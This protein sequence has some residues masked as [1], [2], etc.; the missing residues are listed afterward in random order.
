MGVSVE[1]TGTTGRRPSRARRAAAARGPATFDDIAAGRALLQLPFVLVIRSHLRAQGALAL[2][3][4][5]AKVIAGVAPPA[6]ATA[7]GRSA[8]ESVLGPIVLCA[9]H[10]AEPADTGAGDG[11]PP[12]P[13]DGHCS[14]CTLLGAFAAIVAPVAAMLVFP[15]I[16]TRWAPVGAG[17]LPRHL[18]LGLNRSR[19]PPLPA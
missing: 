19:G 14:L 5:L 3:V 1:R 16:A 9:A 10:G 12:P 8:I 18:G 4:L 15:A 7:G 2:L 13:P 17:L 11:Q 6:A